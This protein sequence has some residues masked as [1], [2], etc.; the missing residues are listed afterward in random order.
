[1]TENEIKEEYEKTL[2]KDLELKPQVRL[3]PSSINEYLRC[4][5]CYFYRYIAKLPTPPNVHLI[6]GIVVH[7]VLENF[8]KSYKPDIDSNMIDLFNKAWKSHEKGIKDLE[9]SP[10][11]ETQAKNDCLIILTEYIETFKRRMNNLIQSGKAENNTHAYHL[12]KP[13]FREK[14]YYD[15]DLHCCGFVDR[16]QEDFNG[17]VTIGDYK[18]SSKFGIGLPGNY[19]LQL[20]I[21]SLLYKLK[22]Q[23]MP[24]FAAVIFLRYGEEYIIEVTPS[25]LQYALTTIQDVWAKTR[26]TAIEDYPPNEG[27]SSRWCP[28]LDIHDGTDEWK[29]KVRTERIKDMI[30]ETEK[31]L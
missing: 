14:F 7:T 4:P 16:I 26:S 13:K 6:K 28:F 10:E 23:K 11:D 17:L 29:K 25:L 27:E 18:T 5:R 22:E 20:A 2:I 15:E 12:L 3:S 21:Y 8:F 31:E 19:K 1:M 30:K 9:L 24:D